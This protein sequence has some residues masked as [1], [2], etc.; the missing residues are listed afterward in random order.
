MLG[1]KVTES[2]GKVTSQRYLPGDDYRYIKMEITIEE[3][4]T[5]LGQQG[6]N[7]GTYT[8]WERVPGQI[9]A[10]GQG[11][12]ATMDGEDAIWTG[13]GVGHMTG[14]AG[15]ISFRFSIAFQAGGTGKLAALN[16]CLVVGEHEVSASGETQTTGW[17]WK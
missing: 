16:N 6:M 15:A 9:Y 17:E 4:G 1:D 12:I 14:D 8:A 13:H 3:Q 7:M 10:T 2:R 11:L 5:I